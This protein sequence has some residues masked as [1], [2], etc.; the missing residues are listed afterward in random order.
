MKAGSAFHCRQPDWCLFP[1][2]LVFHSHLFSAGASRSWQEEEGGGRQEAGRGDSFW[3]E[4]K[5]W[6]TWLRGDEN[7]SSPPLLHPAL[8]LSSGTSTRAR[9]ELSVGARS[10]QL[11]V[12]TAGGIIGIDAVFCQHDAYVGAC[13]ADGSEYITCA[14]LAMSKTKSKISKRRNALCCW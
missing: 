10:Q 4:E 5:C 6:G 14:V 7:H 9:T 11:L 1:P 12:H 3:V 2:A 13:M 8:P